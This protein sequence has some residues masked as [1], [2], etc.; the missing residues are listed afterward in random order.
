MY[1]KEQMERIKKE[2]AKAICEGAKV[3]DL[4]I[5]EVLDNYT[6]SEI[7][8]NYVSYTLELYQDYLKSIKS[9][10]AKSQ[11]LLLQALKDWDV[12]DNQMVEK[13]NPLLISMYKMEHKKTAI[14]SLIQNYGRLMTEDCFIRNHDLLIQG[15]SSEEKLGLRCD[16]LKFVGN[17][18][19]GKRHIEYFP[20][21]EKDIKTALDTFISYYNTHV[22]ELN[23]DYDMFIRPII[24]HGLIAALQLFKDGNTRY[25]RL[26]QHVELWGLLNVYLKQETALPII[27]ATRQYYA[28]RENYRD[29]ITKIVLN[30]D[31]ESWDEWIK[32]NLKC[33]QN[34]IWKNEESIKELKLR[35]Y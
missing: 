24:Y 9:L 19:N 20:L 18:I 2:I 8:K 29:L 3:V 1:T 13:E 4:S 28:V 27:Y 30:N 22:N 31:N 12:L 32:F 15:S 35:K 7:V 5:F 11:E 34:N 33:L 14:D 23:N 21:L 17:N 10:D 26:I 25:A 6:P 16:D